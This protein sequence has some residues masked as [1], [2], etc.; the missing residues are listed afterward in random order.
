LQDQLYD[1]LHFDRAAKLTVGQRFASEFIQLGV[2]QPN[3]GKLVFIG[4]SITQGSQR[5][6]SYRYQVFKHLV[7]SNAR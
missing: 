4:D 6:P 3:F 2:V 7:D 5:E 1:R